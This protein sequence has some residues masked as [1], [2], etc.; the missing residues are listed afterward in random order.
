MARFAWGAIFRGE[1]GDPLAVEVFEGSSRVLVSA[2]D[3]LGPSS[4]IEELLVELDP[5]D[6]VVGDGMEQEAAIFNQSRMEHFAQ[7]AQRHFGISG[8]RG[9]PASRTSGG[10]ATGATSPPRRI[11]GSITTGVWISGGFTSRGLT[12]FST[13]GR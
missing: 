1:P 9:R 5:L 8:E 7:R 2:G 12:A 11:C 6:L 3:E 10:G 4:S 13:L